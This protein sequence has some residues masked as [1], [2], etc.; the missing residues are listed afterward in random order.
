V[1]KRAIAGL[2]EM[3]EDGHGFAGIHCKSIMSRWHS[4][5]D[6]ALFLLRLIELPAIIDSTEQ[7]EYLH[8][9]TS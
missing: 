7:L 8:G 3:N 9:E 6:E 2:M 1:F 4:L 5:G